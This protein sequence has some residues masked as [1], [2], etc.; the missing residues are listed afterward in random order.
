[1]GVPGECFGEVRVVVTIV[2]AAEHPR[3]DVELR[4]PTGGAVSASANIALIFLAVAG[5]RL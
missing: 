5:S 3:D 4:D 2:D 1:V